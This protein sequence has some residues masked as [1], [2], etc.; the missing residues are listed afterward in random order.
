[1]YCCPDQEL[2]TA[3]GRALGPHAEALVAALIR[4]AGEAGSAG[5]ERWLAAEADRTLGVVV[6]HLPE[7][8]VQ[9]C[10]LLKQCLRI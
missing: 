9:A 6:A 3:F 4:R 2:A 5:R 7:A 10:T 8:K 1:M